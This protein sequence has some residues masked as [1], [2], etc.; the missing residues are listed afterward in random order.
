MSAYRGSRT[1]PRQ[2]RPVLAIGL[3]AGIAIALGFILGSIFNGEDG[4]TAGGSPSA[5]ALASA[6]A[7]ASASI[8]PSAA[9]A[10]SAS[11][12]PAASAP[13]PVVAAPGGVIPPGS[14]VRV[15]T[16]GLRMREQPSAEST[17]VD[18]LPV[19]QLLLVGYAAQRSDWGPISAEGFAWYPVI[20]LGELTD[21]PPLSDGP[22]LTTSAIG[23]VADGDDTEAYIQLLDPRC[24]PRPV[25]LATLEAM[26]PWEQ[27]ACFGPEQITLEGTFG[28]VGCGGTIPGTF[29]PD[30]MAQPNNLGFLSVDPNARIGPF[31]MRFAPAGPATPAVGQILRVVGHFDDP[32][33]AECAISPGDPPVPLDSLATGLY[34]RE[35]FVV[36]SVEVTGTDPDFP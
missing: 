11:G 17:L 27:L 34:C 16:D 32:A 7:S 2:G 25:S 24:P 35:Q 21:L 23:W 14:I 13:A 3:I 15:L 4:E 26:Q 6:A 8:A 1:T 12:A 9:A 31:S 20:R 33:A 36:E 22:L 30:W 18:N 5:S 28:C 10:A 19:N 29:E